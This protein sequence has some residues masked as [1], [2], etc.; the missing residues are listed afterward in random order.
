MFVQIINNHFQYSK[1]LLQDC[2]R[3]LIPLWHATRLSGEYIEPHW[4]LG[5]MYF[6]SNDTN[7]DFNNDFFSGP[8]APYG[9]LAAHIVEHFNRYLLFLFSACLAVCLPVFLSI[10][11][12]F[13]L[14][15]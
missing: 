15:I 5:R 12:S 9:N 14:P 4:V 10:Y 7:T 6:R 13:Y 8:F 1:G 11:L 2:P 3:D